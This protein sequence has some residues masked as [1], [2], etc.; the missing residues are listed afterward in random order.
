VSRP[1][2][3][4]WCEDCA[5][6]GHRC[7]AQIGVDGVP[8]CLPCADG[9]PC[10]VE[11]VAAKAK[12]AST[13]DMWGE[14]LPGAVNIFTP[15]QIEAQRRRAAQMEK[16]RAAARK[17]PTFLH[18]KE[19]AVLKLLRPEEDSPDRSSRWH[20]L[21]REEAALEV[22]T[23]AHEDAKAGLHLERASGEQ[24]DT[25]PPAPAAVA[26]QQTDVPEYFTLTREQRAAKIKDGIVKAKAGGAHCGRPRVEV[27]Q[28][29]I[30]A[31]RGD[32]KSLSAISETLG[33]SKSTVARYV[34]IAEEPA[35]VAPLPDP[36]SVVPQK[37]HKTYLGK[38]WQKNPQQENALKSPTEV[39]PL[40]EIEMRRDFLAGMSVNA[41]SVKHGV[42]WWAAD[43]Y[44]RKAGITAAAQIKAQFAEAPA[45]TPASMKGPIETVTMEEKRQAIDKAFPP[46]D[47]T[48]MPTPHLDATVKAK[49]ETA[50]CKRTAG[51]ALVNGHKSPC[52]DATGIYLHMPEPNIPTAT[53]NNGK[54]I[55]DAFGVPETNVPTEVI[56]DMLK[57]P[58]QRVSITL[59]FSDADAMGIFA[60]LSAGQKGDALRAVLEAS[61]RR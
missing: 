44:R 20:E 60:R 3:G 56:A 2:V 14:P 58:T 31:M 33:V 16:N 37:K 24:L 46:N 25:T 26:P 35:A 18:K 48:N 54:Y 27:D 6:R 1:A 57:P 7:Q 49:L 41:V 12:E 38:A 40:M 47:Y 29:K 15:E 17:P 43:K 8:L 55:T 59:E 45:P 22:I 34:Q 11:R 53:V 32:G 13:E 4:T 5:S 52:E 23:Q 61:L 36:G 28:E 9:D 50:P 19:G 30:I 10:S 21:L 42:T 51:C 39:T